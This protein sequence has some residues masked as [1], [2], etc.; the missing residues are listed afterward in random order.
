M[1]TTAQRQ[2]DDRSLGKNEETSDLCFS[3][4]VLHSAVPFQECSHT[5]RG[6]RKRDFPDE[7]HN[8]AKAVTVGLPSFPFEATF[9]VY[10]CGSATR[11]IHVD[12]L[13]A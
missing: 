7:R 2:Q 5:T 8:C 12:I 3:T 11:D 10:L 4:A 13:S 9:T 6:Y 1:I